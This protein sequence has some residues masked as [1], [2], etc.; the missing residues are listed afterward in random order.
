MATFL[1]VG[2]M[3]YMSR[4]FTF[5]LVFAI[6]YGLLEHKK[7]LGD[8]KGIHAIIA[9]VI[10]A[11]AII[12]PAANSLIE[13]FTPWFFM[14]IV[15]SFLLLLTLFMFGE[16]EQH[17]SKVFQEKELVWYVVIAVIIILLFGFGSVFGQGL[18]SA[19]TGETSSSEDSGSGGSASTSAVSSDA[20]DSSSDTT[21]ST[22]TSAAGASSVATGSNR[23]NV[24]ATM[25]HPKVLG[26]ML[27]FLVAMFTIIFL[28]KPF[29]AG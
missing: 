6:I 16:T 28:T 29:T 19:R 10:G 12:T 2:L 11:F 8:N 3:K 17:I 4:I 5:L 14:I 25:Y 1:D 20:G 23:A 18:L 27:M 24:I 9:F 13:F 26:L 21:G 15:I 22:S 7:V